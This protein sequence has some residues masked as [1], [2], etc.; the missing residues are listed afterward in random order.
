MNER[1]AVVTGG[2]RGIGRAIVERL[3]RDGLAVALLDLPAMQPATMAAEIAGPGC[4]RVIGLPCD[5]V[6]RA[7]AHC[8]PSTP[9][10]SISK[11]L[12]LRGS[13]NSPSLRGPLALELLRENVVEGQRLVSHTFPLDDV[14]DAFQVAAHDPLV[15]KVVVRPGE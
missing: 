14:A 6:D 7:Q 2:A 9:M 5:I 8:A 13:Y 15:I 11:R 12:Q 4:P 1:V 10:L 3:N